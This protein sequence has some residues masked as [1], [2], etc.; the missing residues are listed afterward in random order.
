MLLLDWSTSRCHDV[1]LEVLELQIAGLVNAER[2]YNYV[3]G[4]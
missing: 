3:Q 1:G 4:A 2:A